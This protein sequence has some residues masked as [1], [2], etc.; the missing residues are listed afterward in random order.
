MKLVLELSHLPA[1]ADLD[2]MLRRLGEAASSLLGAGRAQVYLHEAGTGELWTVPPS[3]REERVRAAGGLLAAALAGNGAVLYRAEEHGP[4]DEPMRSALAAALRNVDLTPLGVLVVADKRDGDFTAEDAMLCELLAEQAAV[5]IQRVRL[6]QAAGQAAELRREM[7]VARA[8]QAGM[9]PTA[10]PRLEDVEAAGWTRPASITGGDGFD[11]WSLPDERLAVFLGD[12]SGHGLPSALVISQVRTLVRSLSE[13]RGEPEWL[14]S[15]VNAR[16]AEDLPDGR[17]VTA[18]VAVVERGG[19]V[20]WS[21]AGQGPVFVFRSPDS[22]PEVLQAPAV[23]LGV[24]HELIA[25]SAPAV[26][27]A[28]GGM[29]L[30]ASDGILEARG[31]G[32]EMLG[33]ARLLQVLEEGRGRTAAFVSAAV[34]QRL[35]EW[36]GGAEPTDDQTLVVIRRTA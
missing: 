20:R 1:L 24:T 31:P 8:L 18:F 21:S 2:G 10:A 11:I 4:M 27:L 16:L 28:P 22:P 35:E 17:F 13:I 33:P 32:L 25:D 30:V 7:E 26:A 15:R 29:L 14:L 36:Q 5:G 12:A 23:P 3:G 6:H 19:A 9:S 34:R